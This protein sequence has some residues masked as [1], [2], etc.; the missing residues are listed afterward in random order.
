MKKRNNPESSNQKKEFS[1]F[2]GISF[3][4]L[5]AL[6]KNNNREW[7]NKYKKE[8]KTCVIEP[9]RKFV[10]VFGRKLKNLSKDF[11]CIPRS[12]GPGSILKLYKGVQYSKAVN[13]YFT[14]IRVYFWEGKDKMK[15][16]NPGFFFRFGPEKGEMYAGIYKFN[17][18]L[19]AAY[20]EAVIHDEFG[21]EL[22]EVLEEINGISD[23]I[24]QG[25][26][27]KKIPKLFDTDHP[28]KEFL[29]YNGLWVNG[30][31]ISR[32][33]MSRGSLME[34]CFTFCKNMFPLHKWLV[35]LSESAAKL[36]NK[37]R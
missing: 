27:I 37:Y 9:A 16:Q 19:L 32:D 8:Y 36:H 6:K 34:T 5:T 25:K 26:N 2:P 14:T 30:P 11:H 13:P 33:E 21:V 20:R 7:L 3:E 18:M 24:L 29:F 31:I 23:Y 28:R 12:D 17:T 10:S 1:G 4:F 22:K 35:I 15:F